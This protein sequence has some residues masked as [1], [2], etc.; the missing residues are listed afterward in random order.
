MNSTGELPTPRG[1]HSA[2]VIGTKMIIF[3]GAS[4]SVFYNTIF[5]YDALE[6]HWDLIEPS[7]KLPNPR[8]NHAA[9]TDSAGNLLVVGGYS[10]SGYLNDVW[11]FSLS[12]KRWVTYNAS[13]KL[14][15]SREL[16]SMVLYNNQAY[17]WG[18]FHE[19]G[20]S[21]ELYV[22]D[23]DTI[24]WKVPKDDGYKPQ[25]RQGH[26]TIRL[27]EFIF[28]IGGCDF[29]LNVCYNDM[30][31]LDLVTLWW[32]KLNSS[33]Q[34]EVYDKRERFSCASLGSVIYMFGGCYMEKECYND[35][36]HINTGIICPRNC[37]RNGTC[38][39]DVCM[40]NPG[41]TGHDC[42][43]KTRCKDMCNYQ[44]YCSNSGECVCYPGYKGNICEYQVNCPGNCTSVVAGTCLP[45]G[46]CECYEGYEE[47][48]CRCK[49]VNGICYDGG[50][51]CENGWFGELCDRQV[52]IEERE[53]EREQKEKKEE[54]NGE[55]IDEKIM[56]ILKEFE[57]I[58]YNP[59]S[60]TEAVSHSTEIIEA[61]TEN[62]ESAPLSSGSNTPSDSPDSSDSAQFASESPDTPDS[63]D[64][65]EF[66]SESL[67]SSNS[68]QTS[69]ESSE[70]S[71]G[72]QPPVESPQTPQLTS[73]TYSPEDASPTTALQTHLSPLLFGKTASEDS[74]CP[75]H[76]NNHGICKE[77]RCLCQ[78]GYRG[79]SCEEILSFEKGHSILIA[80]FLALT[81]ILLGA[82]VGVCYMAIPR[83][84]KEQEEFPLIRNRRRN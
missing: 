73:E 54:E 46:S 79:D 42:S 6:D 66:A 40:C 36:T 31:V 22:L 13:G 68:P 16:A 17:L 25:P 69:S 64:S 77:G 52:E 53:G 62:D 49:C 5:E 7:G 20:V 11:I 43:I 51:V 34:S 29:G 84:R 80:V 83:K 57:K 35:I 75:N 28:L 9:S 12:E 32:T 18:G 78:K 4:N 3:G 50:C 27:G 56:K 47:P 65:T 30:Y 55:G 39:N 15:T 72:T 23:L 67:N 37:N 2:T 58:V 19:G 59:Q 21:D 14:P 82:C 1:G 81:A 10:D 45:N 74:A 26:V 24:V 8:C 71:E 60:D 41:Y 48:D 61:G 33:G 38:R 63:S 76:C 44:G 70:L